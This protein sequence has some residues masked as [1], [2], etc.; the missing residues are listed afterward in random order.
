MV[1]PGC[2][3]AI[4]QLHL[5]TLVRF[6][7]RYLQ[8]TAK[9]QDAACGGELVA[10]VWRTTGNRTYSVCAKG[11]LPNHHA[12]RVSPLLRNRSRRLL[13]GHARV[14]IR[15]IQWGCHLLLRTLLAIDSR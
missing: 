4:R 5:H 14:A 13:L 2:R 6:E 7:V 3:L 10:V 1:A 9:W 15:P 12:A 8:P 11:N